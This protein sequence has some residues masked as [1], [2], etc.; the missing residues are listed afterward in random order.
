M[1]FVLPS[2]SALTEN[3]PLLYIAH[4]IGK[5]KNELLTH[6]HGLS[7]EIQLQPGVYQ[8]WIYCTKEMQRLTHKHENWESFIFF[9]HYYAFKS[10]LDIFIMQ[11]LIQNIVELVNST[12]LMIICCLYVS[13]KDTLWFGMCIQG[14]Q[15]HITPASQNCSFYIVYWFCIVYNRWKVEQKKAADAVYMNF[16]LNLCHSLPSEI[17][18]SQYF[19]L[20]T[21]T[22]TSGELP[23]L[24]FGCR[25]SRQV[26][27]FTITLVLNHSCH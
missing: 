18:A 10:I 22:V 14:T 1:G 27:C 2:S 6:T 11:I 23:D 24:L 9:I 25:S 20:D 8:L 13:Y 7:I 21:H 15:T 3:P 17:E 16:A 26:L 12:M 19:V 4:Y 5:N